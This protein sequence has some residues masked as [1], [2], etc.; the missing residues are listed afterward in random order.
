M[1]QTHSSGTVPACRSSRSGRHC[2]YIFQPVNVIAGARHRQPSELAIDDVLAASFPAS[3]PPG[4]N[5]GLARSGSIDRLP[6]RETDAPPMPAL[7]DSGAGLWDVIE[8]SHR[9]DSERT[10]LQAFISL[11]GAVAIAFVA[12]FAILLVG[13]PIA[14]AVRGLLEVVVWFFP[15]IG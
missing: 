6:D 15:A 9:Y 10:L 5:P 14:L 11:A 2:Q 12:P 3:D 8:V 4:W 1:L 7:D 13:L